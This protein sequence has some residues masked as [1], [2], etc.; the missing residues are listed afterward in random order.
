MLLCAPV[1]TIIIIS[2]LYLMYSNLLIGHFILV[3]VISEL[4]LKLVLFQL[5]AKPTFI[6]FYF[7]CSSFLIFIIYFSFIFND[8][9]KF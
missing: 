4:H 1:I 3:L 5:V 6:F 7:V 2:F 8:C 9:Y